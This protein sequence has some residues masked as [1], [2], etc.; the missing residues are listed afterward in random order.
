[1]H[2]EGGKLGEELDFDPVEV[3]DIVDEVGL[4]DDESSA[5]P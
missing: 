2:L 4:N 3:D 1:M 5:R